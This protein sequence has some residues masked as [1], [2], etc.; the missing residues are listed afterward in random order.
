MFIIFI[1]V[2]I[3]LVKDFW[4]L[5]FIL[6]AILIIILF[7]FSFSSVISSILFLDK[8]SVNLVFLS[9]LIIILIFF[10][11][12]N[13]YFKYFFLNQYLI[14]LNFLTIFLTLSFL[15][16]DFINFYIWFERSLIPI[17]LIVYGWGIQ[18]ERIE[19]RIYLIGYTLLGSFPLFIFIIRLYNS[20]FSIN[21][22]LWNLIF[23]KTLVLTYHLYIIYAAFIVKIPMFMLHLWLPKV[24]VEAS[25]SGSIILAAIILK[26]GAYGLLRIIQLNFFKS[27]F[28]LIFR[29]IGGTYIALFCLRQTDIK[30]LVAYSSVV[31]IRFIIGACFFR[32][33]NFLFRKNINN[34]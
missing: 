23:R 26:L 27:S 32:K 25:L 11:R 33:I 34:N 9:L 8:L 31:H 20:I 15:I 21:F 4:L 6:R 28:L 18:P 14:R 10:A 3:N 30:T 19:A 2:I 13:F 1:L 12:R 5:P 24:H 7:N 29:V 16:L 17:F 22:I